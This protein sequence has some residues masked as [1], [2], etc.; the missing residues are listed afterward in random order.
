M[1]SIDYII[2]WDNEEVYVYNIKF[3]TQKIY[4]NVGRAIELKNSGSSDEDIKKVLFE[5]YKNKYMQ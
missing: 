2:D 5:E 4:L 3:P 1:A